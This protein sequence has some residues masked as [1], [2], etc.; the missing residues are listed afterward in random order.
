MDIPPREPPLPRRTENRLNPM[1]RPRIAPVATPKLLA[2][3]ALLL[4]SGAPAQRTERVLAEDLAF[5]RELAVRYQYIDLAEAVLERVGKERL[6]DKQKERLALVECQVYT[7][8]GKREGDAKKRLAIFDKAAASYRGF[9]EKNPYSELI[10]EAERSYLG[11]VNN[12]GRALELALED[13]LGDEATTLRETIKTVLKD[14]IDRTAALKDAYDRPNL[15]PAEKLEKWRLMLDRAQMLITLGNVTPDPEFL[16]SQAQKELE[17]VA[18][19]AGETSGPGLNAMLALTKLY[20]TRGKLGNAVDYAEFVV[21]ISVPKKAD[22][23]GWKDLPF[24]A[25]AERFKLV[26]L[27]IPDL[28]ECLMADGR[29]ARACEWALYFYNAWKREGFTIS[30]FGYLALISSARV[31]LDSGGYVGGS[32]TSGNLRWF[33]TEEEMSKA[34]FS[35]RDSRSALDL[36]LKTAQDINTENKGN[37]LQVKAQKLISE[38]IGRPGVKVPPDVL[39][40]AALGE[41][42]TQNYLAAITSMKDVM[43]ALDDRDDATRREFM[44]KVLYYVGASF[45]RLDRQLEAAMAFREVT[46]TWKGDPEYQVKAADGFLGAMRS[47][48]AASKG[49]PMIEQLY[50]ESERTKIEA[51][52][53]SGGSADSVTWTQAQRAY[54]NGKF[55]DARKSYLTI[56][57]AA[58]EYE[59]ALVKAALCLYKKN[60]RDGAKKEFEQYLEGFVKDPRNAINGARKL[61]AREEASAQAQYYLGKMAYDA[62]EYGEVVRLFTGYEKAYPSQSEYAPNALYMLVLAQI[63][64][65]DL[66]GARKVS[67]T[68]QETFPTSAATGKAA[69]NLYQALKVEREAADKDGDGA[70]S[71]ALAREMAHYMHVSNATSAEASFPAL[72]V[73]SSLWLELGEWSSAEEVLRQTIAAF[74]D[75]KDRT[76]DM[77]RFVMPDLGAALL[78]QKRVPEAFAVLDPLVPKD[79]SDPR[80]PASAVVRD[81]CRS[82]SGW[83]EP[84]GTELVEVPGVGGPYARVVEFLNKLIASEAATNEAWSCPWYAL[85]FEQIYTLLQWSKADTSQRE[86]AKRVLDDIVSQLGDPELKD[87]GKK[88]GDDDLRKQFLFLR[89]Q[90]R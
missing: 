67:A 72:R 15:S 55:D 68:M 85:K 88:C 18:G 77:E 70:R 56:G 34:G 42:N 38:I 14:G 9:F 87:V 64:A 16:F 63:A 39:F 13:A 41:Y 20:R 62:Q 89:S 37:I 28:V 22:A 50:L 52:Q 48:K 45:A 32:M 90:L 54:D 43:R 57:Q 44:P 81:W 23:E 35:A 83:V 58:D 46:T 84:K 11:L 33:E 80:K 24:E 36:A 75:K 27:A 79:D 1:N 49:D 10:P 25:K 65:K 12:Y 19:E 5:A 60:D 21:D 71:L 78:G 76:Q 26:E 30:P 51:A 4:A 86:G 3:A 31:L 17:R 61:A 29:N 59:K 7:E 40:E 74:G 73:E 2:C 53:A 6:T 69:F 47:V 66:G 8:G 82:V